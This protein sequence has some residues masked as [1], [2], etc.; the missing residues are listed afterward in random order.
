MTYG[1]IATFETLRTASATGQSGDWQNFVSVGS[2]LDHTARWFRLSNYTNK[3]VTFSF[4][5]SENHIRL[6][7]GESVQIDLC[8]NKV[9][10]DG[11]FLPA[12]TQIYVRRVGNAAPTGVVVAEVLYAEGEGYY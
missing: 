2:P 12:K 5:G 4:N 11:F 1:R 6:A 7:N 3:H 9:R 10:K 8:A